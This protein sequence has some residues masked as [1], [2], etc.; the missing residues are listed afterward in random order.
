MKPRQDGPEKHFR[1]TFDSYCKKILKYGGRDIFRNAKRRTEFELSFDSLPE[2]AKESLH[3]EDEYFKYE[4]LFNVLGV[5]I[6]VA[7]GELGEALASLPAD[8]RDIILLSYFMEMTD[9]EIAEAY[10]LVRRTVALRR[11]KIIEQLKK[12][13]EV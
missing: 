8:K 1:H 10:G 3:A 2:S 7:D 11:K 12:L 9:R 6:E 4:Y 13:L 5:D